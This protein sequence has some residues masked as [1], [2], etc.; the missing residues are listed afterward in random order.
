M[1]ERK[2]KVQVFS[3]GPLVDG[4]E[5][6]V[7]VASEKWSDYKLSDGS[8][9]RLKQVILEIVRPIDMYD[10]DG[11]PIYVVRAQPVVSVIEV[12]DHL[13]KRAAE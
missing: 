13:K 4:F 2:T 12:P 6:S 11:N 9:I 7:D 10:A 8:E 5:I 3:G 1:S